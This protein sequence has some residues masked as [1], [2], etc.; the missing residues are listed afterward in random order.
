MREIKYLIRKKK[1]QLK[2]NQTQR[3]MKT[4]ILF[5]IIIFVL[6]FVVG[7]KPTHAP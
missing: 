4:P 6:S 3:E 5:I 2:R 7:D 1:G